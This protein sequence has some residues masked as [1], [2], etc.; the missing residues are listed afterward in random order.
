MVGSVYTY[1][2]GNTLLFSVG[3]T[4][5][6]A[7]YLLYS[8]SYIGYTLFIFVFKVHETIVTLHLDNIKCLSFVLFC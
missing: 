2:M 7:C 6:H 8:L 3:F 1:L 4:A 5:N